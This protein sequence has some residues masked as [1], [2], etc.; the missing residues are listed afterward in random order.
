MN[1]TTWSNIRTAYYVGIAILVLYVMPASGDILSKY[2]TY[3]VTPGISLIAIIATLVGL[4]AF[5][6]YKRKYI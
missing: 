3:E 1:Q 4:G 2:L 6:A 5:M